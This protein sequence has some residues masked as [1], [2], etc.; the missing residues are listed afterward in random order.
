VVRDDRSGPVEP[1]RRDLRQDLAL[2]GNAGTEDVV[3]G[4]D[5]IARDDEQAVAE[6]VDVAD[7][8]LTI[9]RPAGYRRLKNR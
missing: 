6:L 7:F 8:A 3:E 1:E 9:G 2:V 4:R 5:A